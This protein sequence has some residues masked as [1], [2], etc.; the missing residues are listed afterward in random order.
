M[1]LTKQYTYMNIFACLSYKV[2]QI[3][4]KR[5]ESA[6]SSEIK[7]DMNLSSYFKRVEREHLPAYY[8]QICNLYQYTLGMYKSIYREQSG[9]PGAGQ[10]DDKQRVGGRRWRR[11]G[12]SVRSTIHT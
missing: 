1:L 5:V 10:A 4:H 7:K 8:K 6:I 9:I 2:I 12:G 11:R 3:F